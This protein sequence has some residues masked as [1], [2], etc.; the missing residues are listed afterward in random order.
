MW[1][2]WKRSWESLLFGWYELNITGELWLLFW[3]ALLCEVS[4]ASGVAQL[5]A[6]LHPAFEGRSNL[7]LQKQF[8]NLNAY[9][10]GL[11]F[12]FFY[13]FWQTLRQLHRTLSLSHTHTHTHVHLS[14]PGKHVGTLRLVLRIEPWPFRVR[15][16]DLEALEIRG[17][18]LR[19][20]WEKWVNVRIRTEWLAFVFLLSFPSP[21]VC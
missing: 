19:R 20:C 8:N 3:T 6:P 14:F 16:S 5:S 12:L 10:R 4:G 13:F 7:S 21:A 15:F 9:I 1:K 17:T 11:I 18:W 2:T